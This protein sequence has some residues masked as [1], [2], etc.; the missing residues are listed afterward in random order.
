LGG[1]SGSGSD[2]ESFER[3]LREAKNEITRLK[4]EELAKMHVQVINIKSWQN[5]MLAC[6]HLSLSDFVIGIFNFLPLHQ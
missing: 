3:K 1:S 6:F 4:D 2:S 5:K